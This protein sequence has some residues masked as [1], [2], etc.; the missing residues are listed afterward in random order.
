ME[1]DKGLFP[2]LE[3]TLGTPS[4]LTPIHGDILKLDLKELT[5]KEFGSH[6]FKAVANLPY[7]IT[8][9]TLMRF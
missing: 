6:E 7:Y 5:E 1:I 4:N 8:T 9:L 3:E 2:I